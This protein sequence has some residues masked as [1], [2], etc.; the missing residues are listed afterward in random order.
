MGKPTIVEPSNMVRTGGTYDYELPIITHPSGEGED[1]VAFVL[2]KFDRV[3]IVA[4]IGQ[5]HDSIAEHLPNGR[6][7]MIWNMIESVVLVQEEILKR[8]KDPAV[9]PAR[10]CSSH[11]DHKVC[12]EVHSYGHTCHFRPEED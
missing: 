12:A 11:G 7:G 3:A 2:S 1:D 9:C 8:L 5:A 10:F 6:K 4:A